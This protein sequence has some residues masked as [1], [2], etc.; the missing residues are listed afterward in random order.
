[1][2]SLHLTWQVRPHPVISSSSSSSSRSWIVSRLA[3]EAAVAAVDPDDIQLAA[4]AAADPTGSA[5]C[6]PARLWRMQKARPVVPCRV[7]QCG[8]LRGFAWSS[9]ACKSTQYVCVLV[10]R[11]LSVERA[12]KWRVLCK[13]CGFAYQARVCVCVQAPV[14]TPQMAFPGPS[15]RASC[16]VLRY[17]APHACDANAAHGSTADGARQHDRVAGS[18]RPHRRQLTATGFPAS[19]TASIQSLQPAQCSAFRFA[20]PVEIDDGSCTHLASNW[21][22]QQRGGAAKADRTSLPT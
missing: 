20:Y 15:T 21:L 6:A 16:H 8:V 2:H 10:F 22:P 18:E 5:P 14:A 17:P 19:S 12:R 4:A 13:L 3:A 11:S 7:Q 9:V 1:V